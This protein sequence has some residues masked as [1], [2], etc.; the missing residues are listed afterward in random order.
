MPSQRLPTPTETTSR[1][2]SA[3]RERS[4]ANRTP[5]EPDADKL[6]S[7]L[8]GHDDITFAQIEKYFPAPN[9]WSNPLTL[10]EADSTASDM[11]VQILQV[12]NSEGGREM[13]GGWRIDVVEGKVVLV[14]PQQGYGGHEDA[15]EKVME[16]AGRVERGLLLQ[17]HRVNSWFVVKEGRKTSPWDG[18][19]ECV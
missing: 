13:L 7:Y 14:Q 15:R 1:D 19:Q 6:A 4:A 5:L 8:Q 10:Y 18:W 11:E 9:R 16:V 2:Q 3:P 17:L 12:F